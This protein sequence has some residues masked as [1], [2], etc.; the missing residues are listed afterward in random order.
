MD[1]QNRPAIGAPDLFVINLV[2]TTIELAA[3]E[4]RLYRK[5]LFFLNECVRHG[6]SISHKCG[7]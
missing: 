7:A 5:Q 6:V 3:A 2:Q 1:E 4:G